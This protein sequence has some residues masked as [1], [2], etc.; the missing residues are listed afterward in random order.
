MDIEAA[1]LSK[2]VVGQDA[3]MRP[4]SIAASDS[5]N[6]LHRCSARP[7]VALSRQSS[8]FVFVLS[9]FT[10]PPFVSPGSARTP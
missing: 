2:R 6:S 3:C 1:T 8:W 10:W 7:F 5:G 9:E 4:W